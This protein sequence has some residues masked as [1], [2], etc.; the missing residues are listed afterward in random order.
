VLAGRAQLGA[1]LGPALARTPRDFLF[2]SGGGGTVRGLPFQSL[3]VTS[4]GVRSGGQAFAALSGEARVR[5]N[6]SFSV[7]AF[8]DAGYVGEGLRGGGADWHAGAGLGVRY[9]TPIGPLRLDVATP[10]RRNAD[11]RN[12]GSFQIYVGIG[13]AF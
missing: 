3:G 2:Y 1:V 5:I 4:G 8:A 13:Q 9:L 6:P 10:V 12:A 7:A 11:A